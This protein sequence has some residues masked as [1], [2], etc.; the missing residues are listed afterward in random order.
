MVWSGLILVFSFSGAEE[1]LQFDVLA[2]FERPGRH[3]LGALVRH[4]DGALYGTSVAGGIRDLGTVFRVA[5]DGT[6]ITIHSFFGLDG[7]APVA[8]LI[9]G[10][11]GALFGTTAEGGTTGFG[12][13]Y[14]VTPAGEFAKLV[15]FTGS[16]GDAPGSVPGPIM[17]HS[18]GMF[19]GVT[20]AGGGG[21]FGTVFSL[22]SSGTLTT[23][24][25][26]TGETGE[27]P[28]VEPNGQLL[29]LGE[30]L[31]G[32]TRGGGSGHGTVYS[33]GLSG[34]FASIVE[35]LGSVGSRPSGGL[36]LHPDGRLY[37]TTER[38]GA[39]GVGVVFRIDPDNAVDPAVVHHFSDLTGSQPVGTLVVDAAGSL[40]GTASVGGQDGWGTVFKLTTSGEY[41]N[42]LSFSGVIGPFAGAAPRSGLTSGGGGDFFGVTSAGG[43][44]QRGVVYRIDGSGVFE[45]VADFSPRRGWAPSGAPVPDRDGQLVFPMA[46]GGENGRGVL[47]TVSSTDGAVR[48]VQDFKS[49]SG[50]RPNGPLLALGT[51]F[52]GT[53]T[54][55]GAFDRGAIV[56]LDPPDPPALLASLNSTA[57]EGVRGPLVQN[58]ADLFY[59]VSLGG[60][61]GGNGTVF[62]VDLNGVI[63]RLF[64]FSGTGGTRPGRRPQAPLVRGPDGSLYGVTERGGE[65]DQGIVFKVSADQS[66]SI[67]AEFESAAPRQPRGGLCLTAD[68]RIFGT[69]SLGGTADAGTIFEL[70]PETGILTEQASFTGASGS[71][72]GTAPVGP[73]MLGS[74]GTLY[75]MTAAG[76]GESGTAYAFTPAQGLR[77]L[78]EFSGETGAFP[79][80]TLSV[81]EAQ[82]EW[83]GGMGEGEDG[84]VYGVT[85]GGG[86]F[87]GGVG[88]RL[89]PSSS[90]EA[91]KRSF[92]GNTTAPDLD[93]PDRDGLSNILEYALQRSPVTPDPDAIGVEVHPFEQGA[94]L[95][96][97]LTRDPSRSDVDLSIE[98]SSSPSGPWTTVA[99]SVSGSPFSGIGPVDET[100]T[101][102]GTWIVRILDRLPLES[103]GHR[104][105]RVSATH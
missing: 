89:T 100:P 12:T 24:A 95:G 51:G 3:P 30:S 18:S 32:T 36:V 21:G 101:G 86:A 99:S 71:H 40:L 25:E 94:R 70:D 82:L 67:L 38:G 62:R 84:L 64:S 88:F 55:G 8:G 26:F 79:G 9:E 77:S 61:L 34:E 93:D 56:L 4:S 59:G 52:L 44:G 16:S 35:F 17:L 10:P 68:G 27:R 53:T 57:G 19:Y 15:D 33:L 63:E 92:F 13:I 80:T 50:G 46:E 49:P 58:G 54:S 87:G 22:T 103:G 96:L 66:F 73:L 91:W 2:E 43:P 90:F 83:I 11:D 37:G 65:A 47:S 20:A 85:P 78:V 45:I 48:R 39:S 42:L 74:S 72:P 1:S 97:T 31:F 98:S 23:L 41:S 14:R 102:S 105:M 60:G 81:P 76:P 29:S 28:G 75:G 5:Q 6:R 69:T 104:F 7:A